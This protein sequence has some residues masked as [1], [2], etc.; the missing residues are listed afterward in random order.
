MA[1]LKSYSSGTLKL[2]DYL[3]ATDLSTENVTR[4]FQVSEVV[5]AILKALTIG[6]VT[7]VSTGNS[8]FISFSGGPITTSGSLTA[9]LSASGTPSSATYLRGDGT[10][11]EPGPTPTDIY[12]QYNGVV[13]TLDTTSW[14]FT[15]TGVTASSIDN[16]VTI[17]IP[18]LLASVESIID[19]VGI[20]AA[21]TV[22]TNPSTGDVTIT[23]AGVYQ[24][25]A[26]GN[27]TLTG[28]A[29][30]LEYS[31]DVTINTRA[32][33]GKIVGV[34]PG[35]G[36]DVTN[37]VTNPLIDIDFAGND[38]YIDAGESIQTISS[39]DFIAFQDLTASEVK[40]TKLNTLPTN[41]LVNVKSSIDT[42]DIGKISTVES[43]NYPNVW[44]G[45]KMVTLTINDYNQLTPKDNN[46]LYFIVGAGT[47]YTVTYQP[48]YNITLTTGGTAPASAYSVT[49]TINGGACA[50]TCSITGV[51]ATAYSFVTTITAI[52]GYSIS[53][54]GSLTTSGTI[55]ANAT[56]TPTVS[57]VLAPPTGGNCTVTLQIYDGTSGSGGGGGVAIPQNSTNVG[58][59]G[60][61]TG[62]ITTVAQ[63]SQYSFNTSAYATGGYSF[64]SGPTYS[65]FSGTA[66]YA[67]THPAS[68]TIGG[69]LNVVLSYTTTLAISNSRV[70]LVGGA[71]ASQLGWA[72][73]SQ[74]P[75]GYGAVIP[76]SPGGCAR[77]NQP[78][79]SYNSNGQSGGTLSFNFSHFEDQGGSTISFSGGYPSSGVIGNT[80][81]TVQIYA[82]GT[83]TFTATSS[84]YSVNADYT[85]NISGGSSPTAY[86]FN[87]SDGTSSGQVGS[88]QQYT[89][90][91]SG[92][93]YPTVT[94]ASGYYFSSNPNPPSNTNGLLLIGTKTSPPTSFTSDWTFT[95]T[96]APIQVTVQV[97]RSLASGV[98][99][100]VV[101]TGSGTAN[102]TFT[103]YGTTTLASNFT[104]G[105]NNG[106]T[107]TV[108]RAGSP[109]CTSS[110]GGCIN[111]SQG[112]SPCF[113]SY[114][115]P[116]NVPKYAGNLQVDGSTFLSWSAGNIIINSQQGY[117]TGLSNGDTVTL[118]INEN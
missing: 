106:V 5:N 98:S 9:S 92:L 75:G 63:G 32:N 17:D 85:D 26:G 23:N 52:N 25:R 4:N 81:Q 97:T 51:V 34:D 13:K 2:T 36:T 39:D 40:T 58:I 107:F 27:V 83:F 99:Y 41:A 87:P 91:T 44:G 102:Q 49:E 86:T 61:N 38:N 78:G 21:G 37:N 18:G 7:S 55:S 12:T 94:A 65:G 50:S 110:F 80:N 8:D 46:T 113:S 67:S 28:S 3:I 59:S 1:T 56:L 33:A 68:G 84:N 10:W 95:G 11:S 22:L 66:P 116:S 53:S 42:G 112:A 47:T 114:A 20:T 111:A 77:W 74:C 73:T 96:V 14:K 101:A 104:V 69:A 100:T 62:A 57:A 82:V 15:G 108:T 45:Y 60:D 90:G 16:N 35:Q 103:G 109:W 64:T 29:T 88:G 31:S 79:A 30:P 115:C 105:A 76:G 54:G 118:T 19:G 6:T 48:I 93:T 71:I 43:P 72:I 24:A 117:A 89:I 70:T